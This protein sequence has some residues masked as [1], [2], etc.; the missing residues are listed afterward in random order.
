MTKIQRAP[1]DRRRRL[2]EVRSLS[3]CLEN[4]PSVFLE[5]A[6]PKNAQCKTYNGSIV[7][8]SKKEGWQFGDLP[9]SE[10]P[11]VTL[12][13]IVPK[14]TARAIDECRLAITRRYLRLANSV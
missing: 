11:H 5:K 4:A 7:C 13:K 12:G 1:L 9:H 6:K 3:K 10:L 14:E 8:P 2:S